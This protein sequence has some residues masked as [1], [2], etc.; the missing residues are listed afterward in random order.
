[1]PVKCLL[2]VTRTHYGYFAEFLGSWDYSGDLLC[3]PSV[4]CGIVGIP[5]SGAKMNAA[6]AMSNIE[7]RF[8]D[9]G[10]GRQSSIVVASQCKI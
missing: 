2:V 5:I 1:M 9:P 7:R 4:A 10:Y 3:T 6:A 8:P